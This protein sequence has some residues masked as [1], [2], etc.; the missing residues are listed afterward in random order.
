MNL[1]D[2]DQYQEN[3]LITGDMVDSLQNTSKWLRYLG[4]VGMSI[5]GLLSL[6]IFIGMFAT[7]GINE[8]GVYPN[9]IFYISILF[10]LLF[11]I[12]VGFLSLLI[13]RYGNNLKKYVLQREIQFLEEAIENNKNF[14]MIL[15]ILA[16]VY[17]LL[18]MLL[19]IFASN[20]AV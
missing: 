10:M 20:T 13:Y 12:G 15:G 2:D 5:C 9:N 16:T 11:F 19:G 14:W 3:A 4:I 7:S 17:F 8:Q 1:L 18:L 6:I